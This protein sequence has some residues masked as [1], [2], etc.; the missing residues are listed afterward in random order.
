MQWKTT[1]SRS[2]GGGVSGMPKSSILGENVWRMKP[3][4]QSTTKDLFINLK[5]T[6]IA[7]NPCIMVFWA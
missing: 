5:D 6:H 3:V 7:V 4:D 1:E 2:C